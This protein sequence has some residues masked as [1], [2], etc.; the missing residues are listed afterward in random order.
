MESEDR[1]SR[2]SCLLYGGEILSLFLALAVLTGRVYAQSYWNVFGLSLDLISTNLISFAIIS[3]NS[4][5][6]SMM[7]AIGMVAMIIIFFRGQPPDIIGSFNPTL[8]YYLGFV[9]HAAGLS[10]LI[11]L[12]IDSSSWTIGTAGLM[13]GFGYL[14]SL[15]GLLFFLQALFKMQGNK[16]SKIDL[17]LLGWLRKLPFVTVLYFF[18]AMFV[19]G[20]LWGVLDTTQRFGA[21]EAKF[22]YN[23]KPFVILQL[24]SSKGFEDLALVPNSIDVATMK[25]KII[26]EVGG[27]LYVSPGLK[28]TPP[29]LNVRAV[30]VSRILAIQY[31]VEAAPIGR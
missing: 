26:T 16:P 15:G 29:R 1:M 18:I 24:D 3:P 4:V 27:F 31:D 2:T 22:A 9:V 21:N 8:A 28:K 5:I 10:A 12:K 23:T 30:P 20:S 13:F 7:M 25:V 17:F 19:L 14:L 11:V 6:A